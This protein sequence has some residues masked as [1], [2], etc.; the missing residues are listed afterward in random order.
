MPS[1]PGTHHA[2]DVRLDGLLKAAR[3]V[4]DGFVAWRRSR[5]GWRGTLVYVLALPLLF[6]AV[7][8]L[9]QGELAPALAAGGAFALVTAGGALNRRGLLE[10]LVSRQRRYTRSRALPYKYLGVS[11]IAVGT[12][13]AA[14]GAVGHGGAVSTIFAMLAVAGFHLVYGLPRP[15]RAMAMAGGDGADRNL[16]KVL[17]EA[18][19]RLLNIEKAA[20]SLGNPELEQRLLRIARRGRAVLE[21]IAA[22]PAERN[23]ARKFL[24]VYLEGAEQVAS[25]YAGTHRL[26]KGVELEQNFRNVLVEIESAFDRQLDRLAE[27]DLFDLDVRIEVLRQQLKR[28]GIT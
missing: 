22:R 25:R 24:N 28:E 13:L 14:Y 19:S 3:G 20:L 26:A 23:R 21:Q 17:K 15:K 27:Q 12:G 18:E 7:V 6:A 2:P 10:E 1:R 4:R 11:A 16:R 9:A 5:L 8:S